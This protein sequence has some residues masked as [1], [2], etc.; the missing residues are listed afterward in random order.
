MRKNVSKKE[1]TAETSEKISALNV[2]QDNV[3]RLVETISDML[4]N[5]NTEWAKGWKNF[6]SDMFRNYK[7]NYPY[8]GG[9]NIFTLWMS[10]QIQKDL[11]EDGL[12][13][14]YVTAK[15]MIDLGWA[16]K[17][18]YKNWTKEN[19]ERLKE[20]N[21]LLEK[22]YSLPETATE[23]ERKEINAQLKELRHEYAK[24][25]IWQEIL[26]FSFCNF[27]I[28]KRDGK[29]YRQE[30]EYVRSNEGNY[31]NCIR[32]T[33]VSEA[34]A[35]RNQD[36][37]DRIKKS[38]STRYYQVAPVEFFDHKGKEIK[39]R[40]LNPESTDVEE[41]MDSWEVLRNYLERENI[42]FSYV[43][44]NEAFYNIT[45]DSITLPALDQFLSEGE[46]LATASHEIC[47]STG[48]K[49]RLNR[50]Y[51]SWGTDLYA[52][53]ELV[54]E[55]GSMFFLLREGKLTDSLLSQTLAYTKTYL[56][57]I[58][59][60]KEGSNNLIYGINNALKAVDFIYRNGTETKEE[61][62]QEA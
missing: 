11:F 62:E 49:G 54:A 12:S 2:V 29:Y 14:Y 23:D 1:V 55:F 51:G 19:H 42:E 3:E 28:V 58:R 61:K 38:V 5:N 43:K 30:M 59:E 10:S 36:A 24:H 48:A 32:E 57:R 52:K 4:E 18:E 44:Q 6:K 27:Q 26:Y 22:K 31:W 16:L 21:E 15:Q 8:G 40:T 41:T 39:G 56:S 33:E 25:K 50:D 13:N 45:N 17:P 46:A 7:T 34:Y 9:S 35:M 60:D 53:E 20:Y 47:H 37:L